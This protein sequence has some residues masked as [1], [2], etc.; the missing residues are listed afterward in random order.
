MPEPRHAGDQDV[1]AVGA[2]LAPGTVLAAYRRGM[3][4]MHLHRGAELGWWSPD[5]R[6]VIRLGDLKVSRSL[7]RSVERYD[8]RVDTDFGGVIDGCADPQREHGWIDGEIRS[9]YRRLFDLG[10]VHSVET[11][12][13]GQLVGG[14]YGVSIGGLFA[15][16]SMFHRSQDASKVALLKLVELLGADGHDRLL[17]VQ[18]ST[19]HLQ[20]LGAT[21]ISRVAYLDLLHDRLELPPPP[22]FS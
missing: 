7:R 1:V 13:E 17:D 14:L 8:V 2:D 16:E 15:G 18:W 12:F 6:G 11:F 4:P 21:E 9:A 5:P 10:W 3:F 19:T 22:A 20:S